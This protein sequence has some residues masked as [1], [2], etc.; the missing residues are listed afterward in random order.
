LLTA[1]VMM[2][3][4]SGLLWLNVRRY[5]GRDLTG[6][7][8][9]IDKHG[10]PFTYLQSTMGLHGITVFGGFFSPFFLVIDIFVSLAIV[11]A[12]AI[13]CESLVRCQDRRRQAKREASK[14]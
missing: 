11:F 7:W 12:V 9:H 1:I 13:L 10:W 8:S 2:L 4:A 3:A 5:E 6:Y 14:P